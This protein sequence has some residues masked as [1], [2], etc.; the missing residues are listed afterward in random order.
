MKYSFGVKF[1]IFFSFKKRQIKKN[2]YSK[3]FKI[4]GK[5]ILKK[6]ISKPSF[7]MNN[8][9]FVQAI[10]F[11]FGLD[12]FKKKVIAITKKFI[13]FRFYKSF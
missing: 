10:K 5:K 7:N 1:I 6:L 9:K 11:Y 4:F 12:F 3:R 8:A 13:P 2:Y